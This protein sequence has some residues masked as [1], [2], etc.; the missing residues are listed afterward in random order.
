MDSSSARACASFDSESPPAWKRM[1]IV[2]KARS[3]LLVTDRGSSSQARR[4]ASYALNE[5]G[6]GEKREGSIS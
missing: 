2:V 5:A 6:M 3:A 4:A 1:A